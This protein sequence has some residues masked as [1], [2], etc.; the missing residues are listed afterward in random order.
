MG[1]SLTGKDLGEGIIQKKDGR[2][3]ARYVDRFGKR[4]SITG[5]DLTDVKE[6]FQSAVYENKK[7]TNLKDDIKLNE[8]FQKWLFVSKYDIIRENTKRQYHQV[9]TKHIAPML[10]NFYLKDITQMKIR[11]LL[12]QLAED[13]YKYETKNKVRIILLDMFNKAMIDDYVCKNP[14]KGITV[15]KDER[16]VRVL[17]K[18]DQFDFFECVK[19]TFY[20]NL[21]TVA[22]N[23]GLR[24]GEAAALR[25]EDIDW[26]KNVIHVKRT[27]VYQK[28]LEDEK[29]TFH[30]ELPKTSTSYRDI[31]INKR[32]SLALKKQY[33]Q[34][35]IV[36]AKAPKS[37]E[38][39]EQ[40]RDLL[41]VTSFNTPLNSQIVCDVISR[42]LREINLMRDDAETIE[43]FS[44][45]CFRH[46]FA[47]RCFE[48]G[49]APK[50][51]QRY[52]GHA[53]LAMTMDLYTSV[54]DTQKEM[55]MKK[56]DTNL[57]ELDDSINDIII[58]RFEDAVKENPSNILAIDNYKIS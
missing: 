11:E 21:F 4:K 6:R 51:V 40:F 25:W 55:E 49:I 5:K 31:P 53:T 52:L 50:T 54:L 32:C 44:F 7:E 38:V 8:W 1:K 15:K 12:K 22:V 14:V 24:I 20:D 56:L 35:Q 58:E 3:E 36:K 18:T 28:Y 16:D 45:H 42:I 13:G 46:T 17:S 29:K 57:N 41:F 48:A 37:K 9:Y 33:M 2:Y 47:T 39:E 23:S 19:G 30:F 27:L 10:G 26:D 34:K 43:P